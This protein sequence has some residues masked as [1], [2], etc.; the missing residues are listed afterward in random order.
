[1]LLLLL[2]HMFSQLN[3]VIDFLLWLFE[4]FDNQLKVAKFECFELATYRVEYLI[5]CGAGYMTGIPDPVEAT[6][7]K[8][9]MS[10]YRQHDIEVV[11]CNDKVVYKASWA[12]IS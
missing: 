6:S 2:L 12:D 7:L 8:E 5:D 10:H 4:L 1:M 3:K 9:V 11:Y